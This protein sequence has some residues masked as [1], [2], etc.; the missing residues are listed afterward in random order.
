MYIAVW[1]LY[2]LV[3]LVHLTSMLVGADLVGQVTQPL[4]NPLLALALLIASQRLCR[5]SV[6]ALL[7]LACAWVGDLLPPFLPWLDPRMLPAAAFLGA[8][9]L[10]TAALIPLWLRNRDP[11]R[12]ALAIPYGA[13]VVGLFLAFA[14]GAG[15]LL[16]LLAVYA[17]VLAAMAFFASGVN[18][19]TWTGGTLFMLS[20]ALLGMVWF[21]PGA[22]LPQASVG[23]MAT[24][25]MGQGLLVA[26][27]IRT[28]ARPRW[29]PEAHEDPTLP[30]AAYVIVEG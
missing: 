18:A 26:G 16:P 11:L 9:V 14:K 2:A 10:F 3:V 12:Y 28:V 24:Y 6:L 4:A 21:L 17:V 25:F 29:T 30:P 5:T 8:L 23:V 13:V 1:A 15:P 7:A 20:N 22:W 19:L 27:L